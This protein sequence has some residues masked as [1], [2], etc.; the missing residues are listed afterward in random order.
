MVINFIT[1]KTTSSGSSTK[2]LLS[3]YTAILLKK[4]MGNLIY[5]LTYLNFTITAIQINYLKFLSLFN[6]ISIHLFM[7]TNNNQRF[8]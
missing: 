5:V 2:K 4:L 6:K 7:I 8:K 1:V 3:H